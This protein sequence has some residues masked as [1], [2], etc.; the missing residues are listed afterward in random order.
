MPSAGLALAP[1]HWDRNCRKR[2]RL[3]LLL[4]IVQAIRVVETDV[5]N[6]ITHKH[7]RRI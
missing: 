3:A 7:T 6:G 4:Y 5:H 2:N 1:E